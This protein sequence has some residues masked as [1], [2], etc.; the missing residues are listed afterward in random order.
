M[1]RKSKKFEERQRARIEHT[2]RIHADIMSGFG[3]SSGRIDVADP[4][5]ADKFRKDLEQVKLMQSLVER[6]YGPVDMKEFAASMKVRD[7]LKRAQ[8]AKLK[9]EQIRRHRHNIG[10]V[11]REYGKVYAAIQSATDNH[12]YAGQ[13]GKV[14]W[15]VAGFPYS[16]DA[17]DHHARRE[18]VRVTAA[19]MEGS[20]HALGLAIDQQVYNA[21]L[22]AVN[23]LLDPDAPE[24]RQLD[25]AVKAV[26][27]RD[28][29]YPA[30]HFGK[31]EPFLKGDWRIPFAIAWIYDEECDLDAECE[32]CGNPEMHCVC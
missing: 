19:Q 29:I 22:P 8:E 12:S 11:F 17:G 1:S 23:R 3:V 21:M 24:L 32:D 28:G 5:T 7:D 27:L 10:K 25:D 14:H 31:P 9:R 2:H 26:F 16:D 4:T 15:G 18:Y 30:I 13:R 20:S 6:M